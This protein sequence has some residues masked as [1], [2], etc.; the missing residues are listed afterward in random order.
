MC[1]DD[2]DQGINDAACTGDWGFGA[3]YNGP[4]PSSGSGVN[5]FATSY[6]LDGARINSNTAMN[7][8][9]TESGAVCSTGYCKYTS[10]GLY[11][12]GGITI[13]GIQALCVLN[14]NACSVHVSY[15]SVWIPT[16]P[17]WGFPSGAIS[18]TD[19]AR[20]RNL[21]GEI[22]QR[23][24]Q[25]F[26][27]AV[28]AGSVVSAVTGAVAPEVYQGG[29]QFVTAHPEAA[30]NIWDLLTTFGPDGMPPA[31]SVGETIGN[32]IELLIK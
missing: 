15:G 9:G 18:G 25:K 6:Y 28:Y 13:T 11:I 24:I 17:F 5:P 16:D 3:G 29:F 7:V 27:G 2:A 19:D 14:G 20:I 12:F 8:L 1:G 23:P 32:I 22:N 31:G 21:A 26:V 10:D 30:S 4:G